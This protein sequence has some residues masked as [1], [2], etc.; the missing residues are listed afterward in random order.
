[1]ELIIVLAC[2]SALVGGLGTMAGKLV[3]KGYCEELQES[4]NNIL[5]PSPSPTPSFPPVR[6]EVKKN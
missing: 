5:P 3:Y 6:D 2:I 4:G 1:M